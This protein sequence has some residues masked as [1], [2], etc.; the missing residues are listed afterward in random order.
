MT[1]T[2]SEGT[3][4]PANTAVVL[5]NEDT[6]ENTTLNMTT[7]LS[8]VV[9]ESANLL[10]GTLVSI[11]LDLSDSTPYYALGKKDGNIGFYK[12]DDNVT[13]TITLGANKAYLEV[14]ASG[15]NVKC[16]MFDFDNET[17]I[18]NLNAELNHS[19]TIYNLAGQRLTKPVKGINIINGKKVLK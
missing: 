2:G 19:E 14:P 10:K 8:S 6:D 13:T 18:K 9:D 5:I 4:I 15:G 3:E 7:G 12:F 1:T 11:T 16:F 17:S